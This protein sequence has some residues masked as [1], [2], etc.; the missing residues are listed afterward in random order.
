M[1]SK[2][3]RRTFYILSSLGKMYIRIDRGTSR[4]EAKT[5]KSYVETSDEDDYYDDLSSNDL[6]GVVTTNRTTMS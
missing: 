1:A 3:W 6:S 2:I 4:Q 5:A